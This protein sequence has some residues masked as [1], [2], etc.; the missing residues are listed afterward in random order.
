MH[1]QWRHTA[2]VLI[3]ASATIFAAERISEEGGAVR[4]GAA[5]SYSAL[6]KTRKRASHP[7]RDEADGVF[8]G[9]SG[10]CEHGRAKSTCK[11]TSAL[12]SSAAVSSRGYGSPAKSKNR[13]EGYEDKAQ[14]T[15]TKHCRAGAGRV[16][17]CGG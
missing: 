14:S 1:R 11:R 3:L 16:G 17:C 10:I 15:G 12:P 9:I 8:G 7:K 2:A 5:E 6:T 13:V 4:R